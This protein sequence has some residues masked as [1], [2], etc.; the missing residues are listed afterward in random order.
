[1]DFYSILSNEH[2]S[3]L[4]LNS[5]FEGLPMVIAEGMSYGIPAIATD[6]KT[7]PEDLIKSNLNGYLYPVGDYS[8]LSEYLKKFIN[9]DVDFDSQKIKDS[10]DFLYDDSYDQRFVRLLKKGIE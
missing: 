9:D 3:A 4:L 5:N 6:C 2:A 8:K 10:I 1:M 7:G